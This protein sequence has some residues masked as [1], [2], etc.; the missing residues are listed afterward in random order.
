[1][2]KVKQDE[3][4]REGWEEHVGGRRLCL[5]MVDRTMSHL[6]GDLSGEKEAVPKPE[7]RVS[8]QRH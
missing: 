3:G 6:A 1:M 2:D 5:D 7:V 8:R 4:N